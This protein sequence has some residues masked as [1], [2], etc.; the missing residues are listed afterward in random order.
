[1][2]FHFMSSGWLNWGWFLIRMSYG[3]VTMSSGWDTL[4]FLSHPDEIANFDF[5]HHAVALQ[6]FRTYTWCTI[7]W[8]RTNPFPSQ[9]RSLFYGSV[10]HWKQLLSKLTLMSMPVPKDMR[11]CQSLTKKTKSSILLGPL[12]FTK[13][14]V[15]IRI[16]KIQTPNCMQILSI[17]TKIHTQIHDIKNN[18]CS[19][20]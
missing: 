4:P 5:P 11:I 12:W 14:K 15:Y 9:F 8:K 6:R 13:Q 10:H 2:L 1:M 3:T 18:E 17:S 16:I 20:C 7:S 19:R